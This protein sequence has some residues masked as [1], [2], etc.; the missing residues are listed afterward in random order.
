MAVECR[1]AVLSL[2]LFAAFWLVQTKELWHDA[3]LLRL[4]QQAVR[5]VQQEGGHVRRVVLDDEL[6][7]RVYGD[8]ERVRAKRHEQRR[9]RG[10][11][12]VFVQP[13]ENVAVPEVH[14]VERADGDDGAIE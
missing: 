10:L 12:R 6:K 4:A 2:C 5:E 7:A 9:A 11:R 3:T 14:A 1:S 8:L 13:A